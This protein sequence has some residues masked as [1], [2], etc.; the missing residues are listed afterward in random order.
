VYRKLG[1]GDGLG[2]AEGRRGGVGTGRE[3]VVMG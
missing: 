1:G 3:M 2:M